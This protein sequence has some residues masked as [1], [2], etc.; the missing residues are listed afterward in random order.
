MAREFAKKFYHSKEWKKVRELAW[1]RDNGLCQKCLK[2]KNIMKPGEEVH[3]MIWLKPSNINDPF[4]TLNL[5][6]LILLCKDCH[7]N[8]HK[9]K[10]RK[11]K[12]LMINNGMYIN[13]NGELCKQKIHIVCGPPGAGKTT[14]VKK[15]M[16]RGDL[17]V[18]FDMIKQSISL[19]NK[20]E[21]PDSLLSIAESIREVLYKTIE[22]NQ[23][24][25]KT[26]WIV[27]LLPTRKQRDELSKRFNADVI[28]IEKTL[29]ECLENIM[30]DNE[31][32][33]KELQMRILDKFFGYYQPPLKSR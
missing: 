30:N 8:I 7:I 18:D 12:T 27:A 24:P 15:Y 19:C 5:N 21:T 4:I 3:H 31:R 25:A 10:E 9:V 32:I 2:E 11:E 22:M 20:T 17:V 33:D 14:Y 6:N 13:E 28:L 26:I 23:V 29:E 1:Q 16:E